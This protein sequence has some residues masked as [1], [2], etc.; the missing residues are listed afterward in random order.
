MHSVRHMRM[1][2]KQGWDVHV[3]PTYRTTIHPEMRDVTAYYLSSAARK[4]PQQSVRI[5]SLL[6]FPNKGFWLEENFDARWPA[7]RLQWLVRVIH[8]IQ[9]DII[10]SQTMFG[11]GYLTL[12][13]K[14]EFERL[15]PKLQFPVWIASNWGIDI[16]YYG[17]LS[18]HKQKIK[19]VLAAC[20]CY[21]CECERDVAL[22]R[23][24]GFKG[25]MLPVLPIGGGFDLAQIHKARQS[26][27]P[28]KR[29]V[30]IVK[31]YQNVIGRASVALRAC[32]LA[33]NVL[34]GYEIVV[35]LA[36]KE[37]VPVLAEL[38]TE[39]TGIPIKLVS[40]TTYDE[41]LNLYGQARVYIG[42][43]AADGISTSLLEAMAMGAFP[44]QSNTACAN[45]WVIDSETA[46]LV[47]P[48]D[49]SDVAK[50]LRQAILDDALVDRAAKINMQTVDDHLDET[51]IEVKVAAIYEDIIR[52][53]A[54]LIAARP[55]RFI[56]RRRTLHAIVL[57]IRP[58]V[59]RI[60]PGLAYR[61][62]R[63][64]LRKLFEGSSQEEK[65]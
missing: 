35:I 33:A 65:E 2:T 48:D 28:S 56:E 11:A 27:S 14:H 62:L 47:H 7:W 57:R 44:I 23:S 38:T 9:P 49:S 13:A 40:N 37:I 46:F 17:R 51:V 45:E 54:E 61:F 25:K 16:S 43:S 22:A 53:K 26:L 19:E 10:H 3:F 4:L 41:I 58:I 64:H 18:F 31:G 42:L 1:L 30:I 21:T 24:Y 12:D 52:S 32:E 55:I 15:Y 5:R 50:A 59:R 8:E 36:D 60:L 34:K 20:D 6:P 29:R 39:S 63:S